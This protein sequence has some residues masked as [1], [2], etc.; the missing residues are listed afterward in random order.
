LTDSWRKYTYAELAD[1]ITGNIEAG[2]DSFRI[3]AAVLQP[4]TGTA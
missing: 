2:S 4:S 1:E 3:V